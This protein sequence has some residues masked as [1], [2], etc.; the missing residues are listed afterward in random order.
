MN[1]LTRYRGYALFLLHLS[2]DNY[3]VGVFPTE[4]D[5]REAGRVTCKQVSENFRSFFVVPAPVIVP[6]WAAGS[7][8]DGRYEPMS[9][10]SEYP[11]EG[12]YGWRGEA[13]GRG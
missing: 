11:F 7:R 6:D 2:G 13:K 12:V 3:L 4:E 5:A 8:L 9:P 1:E 10:A